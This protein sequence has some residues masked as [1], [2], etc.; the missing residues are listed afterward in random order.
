MA[1]CKSL[2][3]NTSLSALISSLAFRH[4]CPPGGLKRGTVGLGGGVRVSQL[5]I[6][7]G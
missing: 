3:G 2:S 4:I 5:E 7:E 1:P 6:D